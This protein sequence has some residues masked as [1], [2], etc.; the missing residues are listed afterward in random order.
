MKKAEKPLFVDN[1]TEELKAAI[2]LVLVDYSG[3]SVKLQQDLKKRLKTVG[4]KIVICKNT[5]FKLAGKQAKLDEQAL[6]DTIIEGP[7]ALVIT[8]QDPI[9]PLQILA[10][11]S[12][13]NSLP[14][15]KVGIVEGKFQDKEA[16]TTLSTLPS[17][18]A[19]LGQVIGS[20]ASPLYGLIGTLEGN[21]QKLVYILK[22]KSSA[23]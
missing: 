19:L 14:Q 9:A 4:A 17:K 18:D 1:L 23:N 3:L 13:E 7:S 20:A 12:R 22:Q 6:S 21:L 8:E 5:L 15:F 11:F 2:S 16:L 10:K